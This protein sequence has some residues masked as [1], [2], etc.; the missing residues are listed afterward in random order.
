MALTTYQAAVYSLI[1]RY[2]A[3]QTLVRDA[4]SD[5]RPDLLVVAKD[6][7]SSEQGVQM[8]QLY[9]QVPQSGQ[10]GN[11]KEWWYFIHGRGARLTHAITQ[12]PIEW[13][14]P[15]I[16]AFDGFWFLNYLQWL[17]HQDTN[18]K[19]ISVVKSW[20]SNPGT[21]LQDLIFGILNQLVHKG[22]LVRSDPS[23]PNKYVLISADSVADP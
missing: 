21:S 10:W 12:E 18:D 13:D 22:L 7:E 2:V 8:T 3:R 17:L 23:N 20:L 11:D 19:T 16:R 14:A 6:K 1:E 4:M 9:S 15:D 5:L